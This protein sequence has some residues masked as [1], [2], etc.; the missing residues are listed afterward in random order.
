MNKLS[1]SASDRESAGTPLSS[2]FAWVG[3]EGRIR[4][5]VGEVSISGLNLPGYIYEERS[6]PRQRRSIECTCSLA[7]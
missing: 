4:E 7:G 6:Y 3:Q 2:A 5:E 1:Q